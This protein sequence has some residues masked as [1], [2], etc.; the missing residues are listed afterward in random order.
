MFCIASSTLFHFKLCSFCWWGRKNIFAL[1]RRVQYSYATD[2]FSNHS[3]VKVLP[4]LDT[5]MKRNASFVLHFGL[6]E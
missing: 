1:G 2:H 5:A 3:K 4:K 6:L